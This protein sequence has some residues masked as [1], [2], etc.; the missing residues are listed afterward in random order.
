MGDANAQ[1]SESMM[2]E[3]QEAKNGAQEALSN[4]AI[5]QLDLFLKF[6]KQDLHVLHKPELKNFKQF[7]EELGAKIPTKKEEKIEE[8]FDDIPPLEEEVPRKTTKADKVEEPEP[9]EEVEEPEP[10]EEKDPDLMVPDTDPPQE[11]GDANAQVSESMMD[12]AQEAK[13]GAQ[14]ALSNGNYSEAVQQFTI[15][16]KKNPA[17]SLIYANR[18]N[19]YLK[20]KKAQC[21]CT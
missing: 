15:A 3:A 6:V 7:L 14:E 5:K 12:E 18:A 17:S 13:N 20:L 1:V 16:I 9:A 11:M 19:C 10:P 2:D 4:A 21:S 8:D